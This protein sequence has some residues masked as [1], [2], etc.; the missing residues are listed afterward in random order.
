MGRG[1]IG[2][3]GKNFAELRSRLV[4]FVGHDLR[5]NPFL[6]LYFVVG[7]IIVGYLIY[8]VGLVVRDLSSP[9]ETRPKPR[10]EQHARVQPGHAGP[11]AAK[12]ATAE[13][14]EEKPVSAKKTAATHQGSEAKT[15]TAAKTTDQHPGQESP[16]GARAEQVG[17]G[18]HIPEKKRPGDNWR[19]FAFPDSSTISFPES[20]K[21][22]KIQVGA[23][24]LHGIRLQAP[25]ADATVEVYGEVQG[26]GSELVGVLKTTMSQAGVLNVEDH[27]RQINGFD[28]VEIQGEL[29]DQLLVVTVLD[30]GWDNF[31]ISSLIASSEGYEGQRSSY[32][33]ILKSYTPAATKRA[34]VSIRDIEQSIREHVQEADKALIGK[35]IEVTLQNGNRHKGVVIGED[36]N[37]YTL[38]NY[39]F[40]GRY[41]F[42]VKKEDI[43]RISR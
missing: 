25:A 24:R 13:T 17:T 16:E 19:P 26:Q 3:L 32:E 12:K 20:W 1:S 10:Q 37:S 29:G 4:K 22:S 14:S 43:A 41:S 21:Q 11:A 42:V 35:M 33:K 30:N 39:R 5:R 36:E 40:G 31:L 9:Q 28:A 7:G 15:G 23:E 18:R 2:S 6:G 8:F 34:S 38:E 27:K